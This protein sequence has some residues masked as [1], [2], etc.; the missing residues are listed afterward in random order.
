MDISIAYNYILRI[1]MSNNLYIYKYVYI[2]I[3]NYF[4]GGFTSPSNMNGDNIITDSNMD[5]SIMSVN[6]LKS[7]L[8]RKNT[9]AHGQ[10]HI[11][12]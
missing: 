9:P 8:T 3:I 1:K 2:V 6:V 4:I 12:K 11:R 7:C 10:R 5:M